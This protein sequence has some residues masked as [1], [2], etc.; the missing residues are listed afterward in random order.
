LNLNEPIKIYDKKFD[1]I[2]DKESIQSNNS[3]YFSFSIGNIVIPYIQNTEPLEKVLHHFISLI[4]N[5]TIPEYL[6]DSNNLL[7]TVS[8]LEE[9]QKEINNK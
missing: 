8:L 5:D 9:I 1:Q 4:N 7:R 6:N 2:Y 3:S